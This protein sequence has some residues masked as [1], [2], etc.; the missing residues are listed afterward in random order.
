MNQKN[1]EL[2]AYIGIYVDACMASEV[3]RSRS[4]AAQNGQSAAQTC[5]PK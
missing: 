3:T 5:L 1:T 2:I 4:D